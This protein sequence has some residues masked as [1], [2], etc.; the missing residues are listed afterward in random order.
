MTIFQK[1]RPVLSRLRK[2]WHKLGALGGTLISVV[3]FLKNMVPL[4]D[5]IMRHRDFF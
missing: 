5:F 4:M 2:W 1:F 3:L